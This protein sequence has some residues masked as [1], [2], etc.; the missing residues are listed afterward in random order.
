VLVAAVYYSRE[1]ALRVAYSPQRFSET[2][3]KLLLGHWSMLLGSMCE[4]ANE[5]VSS[6]RML[7][8]PEREHLLH[9]LNET[10]ASWP[11]SAGLHELFEQQVER[12]PDSP[13]VVFGNESLSYRQLNSRANKLAHHLRSGGIGPDAVVGICIERSF[14]MVTS[15]LA[16]LKAGAAYLPLDP[17][18]PHERLQFMLED[19]RAA[20]LLTQTKLQHVFPNV[21]TP[22]LHL[23]ESPAHELNS[24]GSNPANL[25][26]PETYLF[27]SDRG[28]ILASLVQGRTGVSPAFEGQLSPEEIKA[29]AVYVFSQGGPGAIPPPPQ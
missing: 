9:R 25:T 24:D 23:D 14:D 19:S 21:A 13:A 11:S 7:T 27:G 26:K 10:Q 3:I 29:V 18:Y 15:V 4:C 20:I 12:T 6:V 28:A 17:T 16:A 8:T 22:K 5:L 2:A 1:I